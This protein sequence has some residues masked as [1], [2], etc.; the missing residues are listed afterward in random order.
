[1]K[2]CANHAQA[3]IPTLVKKPEKAAA[4]PGNASWWNA[5]WFS[6]WLK[7]ANAG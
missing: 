6:I 5:Q 3:I 7:L 4:P 1:M 2:D